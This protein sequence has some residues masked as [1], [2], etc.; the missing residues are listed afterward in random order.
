M[1]KLPLILFLFPL[2]VLG[3]TQSENYIKTTT[4]KQA[5]AV[6][7]AN[8]A[9][10][11]ATIQVTYFDGLG[12]P[13]Q[14]L[15][16]NQSGTGADIITHLE[17]DPY[18]RKAKDYLPYVRST[19]S[20]DFDPNGQINTLNYGP[21]S[22]DNPVSKTFFDGS[23]L[24]RVLK[25]AAPGTSWIGNDF[26]D[27][28]HTV[29]IQYQTNSATE[30]KRFKVTTAWQAS[31]GLYLPTLVLDGM[32]DENQLYKTVT[33]DENWVAADGDNNTTIEFKNK[34]GQ[35]VLK[36]TYN[37]GMEHNTYYVY[38]LYGNLTYVIPPKVDA[39]TIFVT[40][41]VTIT[42]IDWLKKNYRVSN[43]SL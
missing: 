33:K 31:F 36:R 7:I 12:R 10:A 18:G 6:S 9:D 28:D 1:P 23:P 41:T 2:V 34:E 13:I 24:N 32:Y 38:D 35:V 39:L 14:Q 30:V 8:P 3:Q 22:G 37:Q 25:Q 26:N 4:Y 29:K 5:T 20:L 15:A 42:E 43:G 19:S 17:Y 16:H 27:N 11:F 40:N 21:Y